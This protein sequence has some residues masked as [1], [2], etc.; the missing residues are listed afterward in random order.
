MVFHESLSDNKSPQFSRTLL[1]I[2][3]DPC[4]FFEP[5]LIGGFS[6]VSEWQ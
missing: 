4:E 5:V 6:L 1:S 3:A 2:L